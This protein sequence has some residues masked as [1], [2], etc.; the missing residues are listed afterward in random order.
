MQMWQSYVTQKHTV[1]YK[2]KKSDIKMLYCSIK[3]VCVH[4]NDDSQQRKSEGEMRH[5]VF[6]LLLFCCCFIVKMAFAFFLA[7][8]HCNEQPVENCVLEKNAEKLVVLHV[9]LLHWNLSHFARVEYVAHWNI[10]AMK[11]C[12][13]RTKIPNVEYVIL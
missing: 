3:Y 4:W 11:E 6:I 7:Q 8:N 5:L 9:S 2:N 1:S 10:E 12:N 13:W